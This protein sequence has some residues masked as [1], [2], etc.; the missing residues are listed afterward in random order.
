MAYTPYTPVTISGYNNSA[1]PDDGTTGSNNLISWAGIKTN[2]TDPLD[3]AVVSLN[4]NLVTAFGL[5][6]F[7]SKSTQSSDYT[8]VSA[9]YG[10]ILACSS[11]PTI[12]L[13]DAASVGE[14]WHISILNV[15]S[16]LVLIDGNGSQTINGLNVV[17]LSN[18]GDFAI[19]MSDGSN[20][21][22]Q[23]YR[24]TG[25]AGII[26]PYSVT[27]APNGT[28]R[29]QGETIG[30]AGSGATYTGEKYRTLYNIVKASWGNVGTENFD[31]LNTVLLPNA[32][33]R[34]LIDGGN[35]FTFGS[36]G[37]SRTILQANLPSV[38]FLS[39]SLA[40]VL[41]STAISNGTSVARG[42]P[43]VTLSV[44]T[45]Q[46]SPSGSGTSYVTNVS[47]NSASITNDTIAVNSGTVNVSGSVPSGGSGTAYDQPW[48]SARW[49]ITY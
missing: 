21:V 7:R 9:D 34:F 1:P 18:L 38:N 40:A 24:S 19:L 12:T 28:I 8:T 26:L 15:G 47:V 30:A 22:G 39:S 44:S 37:G 13:A 32:R 16:G 48:F 4:T 10:K 3:T 43:S 23:V 36:T 2:L 14:G 31:S 25:K 20:F 35:T 49:C 41:A 27:S 5:R 46:F 6:A 11:S 45:A 17:E 33:D 29:C 42:Q